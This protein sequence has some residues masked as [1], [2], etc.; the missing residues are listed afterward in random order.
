MAGRRMDCGHNEDAVIWDVALKKT[1]CSS[2]N[3]EAVN[4]SFLARLLDSQ[5]NEAAFKTIHETFK[6]RPSEEYMREAMKTYKNMHSSDPDHMQGFIKL[7]EMA[8][9]VYNT[10][11]E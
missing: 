1:V 10:K 3:A 6:E 2:C 4:A 11:G 8:L 9:Q 5:Q 7:M